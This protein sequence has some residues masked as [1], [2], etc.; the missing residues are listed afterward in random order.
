MLAKGDPSLGKPQL[1]RICQLLMVST[2]QLQTR[3][4]IFCDQIKL[5]LHLRSFALCVSSLFQ[6]CERNCDI[7]IEQKS[8]RVLF[9]SCI[10]Q[11]LRLDDLNEPLWSWLWHSEL[12]T[13]ELRRLQLDMVSICTDRRRITRP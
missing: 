7:T 12:V 2:R 10:Q 13:T 11:Q 6:L 8:Q 5:S 4:F 9:A 1:L 3:E